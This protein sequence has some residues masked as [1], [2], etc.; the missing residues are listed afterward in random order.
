MEA[1]FSANNETPDREGLA[2]LVRK[3]WS[4]IKELSILE[5]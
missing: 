3:P 1:N 2:F 4:L 5:I